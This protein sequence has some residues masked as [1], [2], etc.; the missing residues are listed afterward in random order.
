MIISIIAGLALSFLNVFAAVIV[1]RKAFHKDDADFNRIFF[2]SLLIRFF[3]MIFFAW[4]GIK[5]IGFHAL[6]FALTLIAGTF[7]FT[8]GEILYIHDRKK[9]SK[10]KIK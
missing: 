10:L 8:I 3:L 6:A 7:I 9:K 1:I 5:L 2:S 4:A